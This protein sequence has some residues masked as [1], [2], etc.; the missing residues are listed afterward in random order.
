MDC[1]R[2]DDHVDFRRKAVA[3]A[4][5]GLVAPLFTGPGAMLVRPDDG[6]VVREEF[7]SH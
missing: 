3:R 4:A 1:Q 6:G 2:I 5:D 7:P